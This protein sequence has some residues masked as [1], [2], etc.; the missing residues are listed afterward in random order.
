MSEIVGGSSLQLAELGDGR[1]GDFSD[2][3]TVWNR[4]VKA[5]T[6]AEG[7]WVS[8]FAED[9][10]F[11]IGWKAEGGDSEERGDRSETHFE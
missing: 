5:I 10:V 4:Q 11:N 2:T 1:E 6:L 7:S 9:G 8:H 3:L